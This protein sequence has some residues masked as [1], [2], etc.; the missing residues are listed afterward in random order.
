MDEVPVEQAGSLYIEVNTPVFPPLSDWFQM[1][2]DR[3]QRENIQ[4]W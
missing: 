3:T 4:T 1:N 2:T